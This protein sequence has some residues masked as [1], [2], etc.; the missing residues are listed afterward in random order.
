MLEF[1]LWKETFVFA[2][3]YSFII[4]VPCVLVAFVGRGMIERLGRFPTK[5]PFIQMSIFFQLVII[6]A[7]TFFGLIGF[8]QFFTSK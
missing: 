1:D 4:L 3:V 6:E 7:F 5:T 8:Y 2:V